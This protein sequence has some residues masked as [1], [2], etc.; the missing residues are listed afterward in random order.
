MTSLPLEDRALQQPEAPAICQPPAGSSCGQ[1]IETHHFFALSGRNESR[2]VQFSGRQQ[3]WPTALSVAVLPYRLFP[4]G[5]LR[6]QKHNSTLRKEKRRAKQSNSSAALL[7]SRGA[8]Q[9]PGAVRQIVSMASALS[10]DQ[11]QQQIGKAAKSLAAGRWR[12]SRQSIAEFAAE[13][14]V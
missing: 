4:R 2:A 9:P 6:R 14:C 3:R 12:L 1:R 10:A 5:Q 13:A 11:R 7:G 8:Q